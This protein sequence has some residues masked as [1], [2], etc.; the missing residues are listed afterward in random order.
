[1]ILFP[2]GDIGG[3]KTFLGPCALIF[4]FVL[5]FFPTPPCPLWPEKI[6]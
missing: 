3:T 6:D 4:P 5:S 1:M 2:A